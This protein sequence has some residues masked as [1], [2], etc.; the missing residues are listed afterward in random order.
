MRRFAIVNFLI[1]YLLIYDYLDLQVFELFKINFILN[2]NTP[3]FGLHHG[4][5]YYWKLDKA[6]SFS[7]L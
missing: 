7:S 6:H 3:G 5:P 4:K 1:N 2:W